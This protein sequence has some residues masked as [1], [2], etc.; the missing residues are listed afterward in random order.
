MLNVTIPMW[1]L[2]AVAGL[3][4]MILLTLGFRLMRMKRHRNQ[5][6]QAC[7]GDMVPEMSGGFSERVS[8][9]MWQQQVDAIF[10]ALV[11]IIETEKIKLKALARPE[12]P[13]D[14]TSRRPVDL[15]PEPAPLPAEAPQEARQRTA[16][17]GEELTGISELAARGLLSD[18]VVRRLGLSQSEVALA[19]KLQKG[20]QNGPRRRIEAVA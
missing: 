17:A 6:E 20:R 16:P 10:D 13:L 8:H 12:L 18:E 7:P 11:T 19:M 5:P 3:P 14:G 1:V 2:L 9:L 4:T 15:P